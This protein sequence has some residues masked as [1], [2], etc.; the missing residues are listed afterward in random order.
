MEIPKEK[1]KNLWK[2]YDDKYQVKAIHIVNNCNIIELNNN[3]FF[4]LKVLCYFH[5]QFRRDR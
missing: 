1:P 3:S 4:I 2:D 5:Y